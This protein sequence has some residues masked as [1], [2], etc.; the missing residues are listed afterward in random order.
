MLTP[1]NG[2][3]SPLTRPPPFHYRLV[4]DD[5]TGSDGTSIAGRTPDISVAG[6]TWTLQ[7]GDARISSNQALGF[8]ANSVFT[9][10]S[11][12]AD[13]VIAAEVTQDPSAT[14]IVAR[15]LNDSS[16]F[17]LRRETSTMVLYEKSG[18]S[19]VVRASVAFTQ[20]H[21]FT[22]RLTM[23]GNLLIGEIMGFPLSVVSYTSAVNNTITMHGARLNSVQARINN[24]Q[25]NRF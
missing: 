16:F 15:Y 8:A 7:T 1:L 9:V 24:I 25:I 10:D 21:P 20:A 11:G 3:L 22:L 4:S 6:A 5:F 17:M 12:M 14:G 23:S 19:F 13:G 2:A 18:G